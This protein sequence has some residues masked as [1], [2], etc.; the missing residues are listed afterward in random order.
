MRSKRRPE[1]GLAGRS[2][3]LMLVV[4]VLFQI[5]CD[6]LE[7]PE[8]GRADRVLTATFIDVGQGDST[9]FELPG[10]TVI[11]IDGGDG[12]HGSAAV[13]DLLRA[14]SIG[15]ID[16][17]VLTHPHADHVGG[18]VAVLEA[19]DV[20]EIWEGGAEADTEA[21]R[22]FVQARDSE[23]ALVRVPDQSMIRNYGRVAIE[24]LNR[25]EG[26][27]GENN[28]SLVLKISYGDTAFLMTGD[29]EK[30]ETIDLLKDWGEDLDCDVLKVPHHGSAS[31]DPAFVKA[32]SPEL[33]VISVGTGNPYGQPAEETVDAYLD[34][35]TAL[36]RTD[37]SGSI[38]VTTDGASLAFDCRSGSIDAGLPPAY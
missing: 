10:G 34:T 2:A 24:V 37:L 5:R 23:G 26:Y 14:K 8:P 16:L 12:E 17:L 1:P 27:A 18:L 32:T 3:P 33:A 31:F 6:S 35:G 30:E 38:T 11:L 29:V 7:M 20:L 25:E 36:C 13:L 28:D 19:L 4:L 15:T 22:N 21:Y 9:L